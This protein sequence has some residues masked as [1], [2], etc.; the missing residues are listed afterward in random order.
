MPRLRPCIALALLVSFLAVAGDAVGSPPTESAPV[1]GVSPLLIDA[2]AEVWS[3]VARNDNPIWPGWNAHDTPLL[4]Y[5]PGQQDV[6]INHPHP[7]EGFSPYH[8]PLSFPGAE[9]WV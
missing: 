6:L 8:G 3:V 5:L 4:L 9:M 2:G 7:A 1:I